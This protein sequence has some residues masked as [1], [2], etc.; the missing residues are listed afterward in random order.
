MH[1]ELASVLQSALRHFL[2]HSGV[3]STE[4]VHP[5]AFEIDTCGFGRRPKYVLLKV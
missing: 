2:A 3:Y 5:E 1:G 4:H